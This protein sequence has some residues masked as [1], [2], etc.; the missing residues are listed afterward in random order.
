MKRSRFQD[1]SSILGNFLKIC[2]A[3]PW[4]SEIEN[5]PYVP[6]HIKFDSVPSRYLPEVEKLKNLVVWTTSQ[7]L[8]IFWKSAALLLGHGRLKF[9]PISLGTPKLMPS[10]P[11]TYRS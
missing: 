5:L 3:S 2:C 6:G 9:S 4:V 11:D 8:G 10:F 1:H 7:F